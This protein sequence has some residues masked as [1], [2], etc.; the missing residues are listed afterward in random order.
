MRR[1]TQTRVPA[2]DTWSGR[3]IGHNGGVEQR[4]RFVCVAKVGDPGTA[5]ILAARLQAEN[6]EARVHSE[7][8][9]PYPLT[10]G[11]MAVAEIW[12]AEHAVEEARTIVMDSE[13]NVLLEPSQAPPWP[14]SARWAAL[15]VAV[16]LV[17]AVV[18]R[19]MRVF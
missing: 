12:V 16:V 10:V 19:L 5:Q 17:V 1:S 3:I 15:A 18:W 4:S 13:I 2:A 11:Q 14:P 8:L 7:A 6:I 9:G